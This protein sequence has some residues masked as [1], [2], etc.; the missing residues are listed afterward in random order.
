MS[1]ANET[2]TPPA[3]PPASKGA[4]FVRRLASTLVLWGILA[5]AILTGN[6]WLFL[7]LI[8]VFGGASLVEWCRMFAGAITPGARRWLYL[9]AALYAA[10][11]VGIGERSGG[12]GLLPIVAS[13]SLVDTAG[14]TLLLFGLFCLVMRRELEGRK[15][16]W[17]IFAATVGF[18]YIPVLFSFVWRVLWIPTG[19]A[20]GQ[21]LPGVF[22]LLFIVMVTKFSDMGAY[23][24]GI[25]IGRKKMIPHISPGKT[26][27]GLG[28]A[29]FGA[30]VG[31][32]SLYALA[33]AHLQVLSWPVVI[34]IIPV[35]TIVAVMA[36][37]AESVIKRCV[38]VK[39]SGHS[40][41]G[42]GGALD[43]IDSL[44]FTVP[45]GWLIILQIM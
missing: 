14:L 43:L 18:L 2:P 27:E 23:F 32:C 25:L 7:G 17:L 42:I 41:P 16:L 33:S 21:P 29:F 30:Y 34:A 24:F 11:I 28:G 10:A 13:W 19:A 5:A 1:D 39:D 26:W 44:L 15:T 45:L 3:P 40:L 20:P 31:G 36:D 4:V 22:Y 35:L 12:G 6:R 9:V 8:V 38:E 37:L